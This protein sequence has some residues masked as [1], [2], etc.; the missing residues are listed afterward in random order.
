MPCFNDYKAPKLVVCYFPEGHGSEI[1]II[2]TTEI[3]SLSSILNLEHHKHLHGQYKRAQTE[4]SGC[5]PCQEQKIS[6]ACV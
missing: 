3:R 6:L 1:A 2:E 5:E 4:D